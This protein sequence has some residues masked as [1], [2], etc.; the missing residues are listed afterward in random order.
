MVEE[1][2]AD[3]YVFAAAD[4][5]KL[6]ARVEAKRAPERGARISLRPQRRRGSSLRSGDGEPDL[7]LGSAAWLKRRCA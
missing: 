6:V 5:G 7:A 3:A 1:I 4:V 2:G